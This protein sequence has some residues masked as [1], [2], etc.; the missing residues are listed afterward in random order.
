MENQDIAKIIT[1]AIDG[2]SCEVTDLTG[3]AD[4]W[5]VKV[6]WAGFAELPLIQQHKKVLEAVRPYMTD[7]TNEIHAV[8]IS[9]FSEND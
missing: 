8:Q 2:A 5:G 7:G 1:D 6:V 4:P 9:T 3:T